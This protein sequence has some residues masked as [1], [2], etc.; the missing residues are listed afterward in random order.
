MAHPIVRRL[1]AAAAVASAVA[2]AGCATQL[3]PRD[4]V[5]VELTDAAS[6]VGFGPD[7]RFW[8]DVNDV[9][10]IES[11]MLERARFLIEEFGDDAA[12]GE[13][14]T[15]HYLALSGGGQY[16]AFASGVLTEWTRTGTRP[17]FALVSGISTGSI[18]APF[19]FLGSKYDSVL[20]EV[21]TRTRTEDLVEP[22]F[23]TGIFGGASLTDTQGLQDTIARYVTEDFLEEIAVE[24]RKG[25]RLLVGTTNIDAGRSVIWDMGAIADSGRPGALQL[26]RKLIQASAAIPVAFPPVFFDVEAGGETYAEMHVDGGVTSQVSV[27]SPQVPNYLI[28]EL[29]GIDVDRKLYVI[30]NGAVRAPAKVVQPRLPDIAGASIDRLWYAQAVGDLYRIH[31]TAARD[32]IEASYTWIPA[33]FELQPAEQ[34]DPAFMTELFNL[35]AQLVRDGELWSDSPPGFTRRGAVEEQ[36]GPVRRLTN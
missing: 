21:Y 24:H 29:T 4:P 2:L 20:E 5:P 36:R 34:F 35:G 12:R 6:P 16:G 23:F 10:R 28:D 32:E 7:I 9:N 11:A 3:E 13:T 18:I 33:D 19:A 22:Q 25:R 30:V 17:T 26:F 1:R 8:G 31:A 14:P 27:L 15:F